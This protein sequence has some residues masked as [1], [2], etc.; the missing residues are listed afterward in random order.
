MGC[1]SYAVELSETAARQR[2]EL[3]EAH[4]DE[5]DAALKSLED[6]SKQRRVARIRSRKAPVQPLLYLCT[7]R[8]GMFHTAD[9][10]TCVK[11]VLAIL[12]RPDLTR[13]QR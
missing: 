2:Q 10:D 7:P 13:S 5:V 1:Q 3:P 8:F 4:R 6:P 9:E 12:R 11:S